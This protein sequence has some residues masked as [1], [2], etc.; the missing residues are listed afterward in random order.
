MSTDV[1]PGE[2]LGG[3]FRVERIVGRGGMGVVIEATN[4]Q[5]DQTV[6]LKLLARG[7][8]DPAMVE[9]FTREAK[10]AARLKSEHV[11]RVYDVGKDAT[12][13]PFI[14]MEML[15]GPSPTS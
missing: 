5:I 11:A 10:A 12:H 4:T 1:T 14:V 8:E 6:A 13:G 3:K 9:R 15:H 7:A 2:M